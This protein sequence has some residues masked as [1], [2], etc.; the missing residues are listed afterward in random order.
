[1][2]VLHAGY[3]SRAY[4]QTNGHHSPK[5]VSRFFSACFMQIRIAQTVSVTEAEGP[6][7]RFA[8]WVQG[9]PLRCAECCNPEMLT[10]EGG[11]DVEMDQLLADIL[12]ARELGIE[13]ITLIGGEPFAHASSL[14]ALAAEVRKAGLSVMVFSGY[15]LSELQ[16]M[17]DDGVQTLLSE[18][19]IL[20]D[21][22]YDRTQPDT[23]RRWIGS[24]NQ[25]IHFLSDRYSADD[26]CWTKPDTLEFRWDGRELL[27]NGFPAK[28]AV[29][30]WRSI[31]K[32]GVE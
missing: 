3:V 10:F 27:V 1:M 22:R 8:I 14:S 13:G 30:M 26:S 28:P 15:M 2:F 9:C 32:S 21:G 4:F 18:T 20:V 16:Q 6:G 29:S 31:R 25:Q 12:A 17:N 24:A 11:S 7:R 19:D 5:D 23:T